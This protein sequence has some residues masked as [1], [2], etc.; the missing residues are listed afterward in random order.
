MLSRQS[1]RPGAVPA[2]SDLAAGGGAVVHDVGAPPLE[3]STA[4]VPLPGYGPSRGWLA[5]C[6]PLLARGARLGS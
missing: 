6:P 4:H 3:Q 2:R 5:T 1:P